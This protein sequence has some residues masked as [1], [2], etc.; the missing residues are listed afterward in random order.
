M[1]G[2]HCKRG[3]RS[4]GGSTPPRPDL[5]EPEERTTRVPWPRRRGTGRSPCSTVHPLLRPTPPVG[6]FHH[7]QPAQGRSSPCGV[8]PLP[9]PHQSAALLLAEPSRCNGETMVVSMASWA[10]R[11][12][13]N[14]SATTSSLLPSRAL[15]AARSKSLTN[16][17]VETRAPASLQI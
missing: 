16:T 6:P 12:K 4:T 10:P 15:K 13:V 17:F 14:P 7:H 2:L 3:W 9:A 8:L 5:A 1:P 11:N